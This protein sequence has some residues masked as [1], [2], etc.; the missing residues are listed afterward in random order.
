VLI[1]GATGTSGQLAVQIAKSRG[2]SHI[3]AAGR[4]PE[5]LASLSDLGATRTISL[6]Q[7]PGAL[8]A[9][10]TSAIADNNIRVVLDYLYGLPAEATLQA[11]ANS[12]P[13]ARIRYIQIGNLAGA[14]IPLSAHLLRSTDIELLGSGYG[15]ADLRAIRSAIGNFFTHISTNRPVFNY[16]THPLSEIT[17]RWTEPSTTTRLVFIP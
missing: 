4:N 7:D 6:T 11:I 12:H 17:P 1:L 16:A 2:A 15:S 8:L 13:K 9:D 10:L 5:A 3:V 14:T